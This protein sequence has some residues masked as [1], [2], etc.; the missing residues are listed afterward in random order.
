MNLSLS[1]L[2]VWALFFTSS[3]EGRIP[4]TEASSNVFVCTTIP[5]VSF[6]PPDLKLLIFTV[7]SGFQSINNTMLNSSNLNSVTNLTISNSDIASIEQGAF[8]SFLHLTVL[9]LNDN[10]LSVIDAA[11]FFNAASLIS[12]S[13]A[14]NR[15]QAIG[16]DTLS[17]F[18]NL[19]ELDLSQNQISTI[20]DWSLRGNGNISILNLS[21]NKLVFLTEQ[22]LAGPKFQKIRLH[23]NPW[24][25]LCEHADWMSFLRDLMN[26]SVLVNGYSV[27][28]NDP[29]HLKG[30]PVWNASDFACSVTMSTA[31]PDQHTQPQLLLPVLLGLLGL[32]VL[33]LLLVFLLL[34]R[35]QGKEQVK[36][37]GQGTKQQEKHPQHKSAKEHFSKDHQSTPNMGAETIHPELCAAMFKKQPVTVSGVQRCVET[38]QLAKG[39]QEIPNNT[40]ALIVPSLSEDWVCFPSDRFAQSNQEM[41]KH[42]SI[43]TRG[44]SDPSLAVFMDQSVIDLHSKSVSNSTALDKVSCQN[45]GRTDGAKQERNG[46]GKPVGM[47]LPLYKMSTGNDTICHLNSDEDLSSVVN[48]RH[49]VSRCPRGAGRLIHDEADSVHDSSAGLSNS[50]TESQPNEESGATSK[51]GSQGNTGHS[52]GRVMVERGAE[53]RVKTVAIGLKS[54]KHFGEKNQSS[55][56]G[57]DMSTTKGMRRGQLGCETEIFPGTQCDAMI[58]TTP[59]SEQT[60]GTNSPTKE[61]PLRSSEYG[62]VNLLHEIVENQGRRTRER[63][64][65]TTRYKIMHK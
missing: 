45:L 60:V 44:S 57:E 47:I 38:A 61:K 18:S 23:T 56:I 11:W 22:A 17:H 34:K 6:Y 31:W 8:N 35:K 20:A 19:I 7:L 4:C 24:S 53:S 42:N 63:W 59:N 28:C 49:N 12:L 21:N 25:C 3:C 40:N 62:Y 26:S 46:N 58:P 16:L 41:E 37:D 29:P 43:P 14:R 5:N 52:K 33:L 51:A 32:L 65:Q 55:M 64:K 1:T 2:S 30:I 13:L 15:I 10:K 39:D 27:T 9:N 54:K 50:L 48:G 36:P